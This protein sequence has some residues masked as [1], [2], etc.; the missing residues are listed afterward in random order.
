MDLK[1]ARK[2]AQRFVSELAAQSTTDLVI[3]DQNTIEFGTGWVFFYDSS[4]YLASGAISDALAGNAPL[5]VSKRD[6]SVHVTGTAHPIEHYIGRFEK[7][8]S[9]KE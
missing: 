5:I 1:S 3:V 6:G 8:G 9:C 2:I 4:R 7:T